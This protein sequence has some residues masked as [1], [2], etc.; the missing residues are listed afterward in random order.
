MYNLSS[1]YGC[2]VDT[3]KY[4]TYDGRDSITKNEREEEKPED[5]A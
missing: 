3:A 2:E 1:C 4:E 5:V